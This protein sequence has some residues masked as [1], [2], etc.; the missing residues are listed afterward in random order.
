MPPE[1]TVTLLTFASRS[2]DSQ[3]TMAE[4]I[5]AG[6]LRRPRELPCKYFYDKRG[7]ELFD[8]ITR[9]P[10][11]YLTRMEADILRGSV[12]EIA[13]LVRPEVIVEL[14][15]GFCTK[16]R[17][18][19]AAARSQGTL[20][21]FVPVDVSP[22]ALE[23]ATPLLRREFAGLQVRGLVAEFDDVA[24]VPRFGRQLVVFLGSTIG[25]LDDD[26]RARFLSGIRAVLEPGDAFLVGVDLVKDPGDLNAAY[27]DSAGVSAE[28]N[29][30]LL[31]VLNREL[32]ANFDV[33][34]F[35]HTSAYSPERKRIETDL[36]SKRRQSVRIPACELA[37]EFD[38]GELIRTEISVKFE[39]AALAEELRSA[40][41][42]LRQWFTDPA[43][44]F[45]LALAT[46]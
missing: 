29:R 11:Y 12:D 31:H 38:A 32:G 19:I 37:V 14:G 33:D 2:D 7:S 13:A 22:D 26:A 8:Q 27:N 9:L 3:Q 4:E 44:W 42:E 45:A 24:E 10:E 30:N 36:R 1:G 28:F 25:N 21:T 34:S 20:Q 17:L 46:V 15:A 43:Q 39:R 23:E 18:L 16:S 41:L 6:L 40:G 35:E 5:R